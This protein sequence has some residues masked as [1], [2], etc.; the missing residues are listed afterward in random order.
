[1]PIVPVAVWAFGGITGMLGAY[2][3]GRQHQAL[4]SPAGLPP[5]EKFSPVNG[6]IIVA[7]MFGLAMLLKQGKGLLK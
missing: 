5:I 6:A 2:F 1:M 4:G 7:G 3:V